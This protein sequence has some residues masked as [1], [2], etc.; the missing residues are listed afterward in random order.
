ME[1][2]KKEFKQLY[3]TYEKSLKKLATDSLSTPSI[4]IDYFINYLKFLRDY[5]IL[6][7]PLVLE[8][9]EENLK[10]A[11]LASAIA[12][13]EKYQTCNNFYNTFERT[14][15][16]MLR[17]NLISTEQAIFQAMMKY[18]GE[19]LFEL[20]YVRGYTGVYAAVAREKADHILE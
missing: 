14:L 18:D 9:G 6:T 5:L 15:K 13:Y 16:M 10:I 17:H 11:T 1:S 12:T 4:F 3:T 8:S 2:F 7:E 19:Q 20:S